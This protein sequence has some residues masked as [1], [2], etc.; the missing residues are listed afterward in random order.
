MKIVSMRSAS[1]SASARQFQTA[2]LR[3]ISSAAIALVEFVA[4][5][6][7]GEACVDELQRDVGALGV[8]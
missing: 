6:V 1:T 7:D 2:R 8:R 4:R 3:R 5:G